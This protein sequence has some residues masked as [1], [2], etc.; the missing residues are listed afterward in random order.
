MNSLKNISYKKQKL[1]QRH[2]FTLSFHPYFYIL[3]DSMLINQTL[4]DLKNIQ[5][6]K[7]LIN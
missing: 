6:T 2:Q 3:Y 4:I 7:T 5:T 1:A